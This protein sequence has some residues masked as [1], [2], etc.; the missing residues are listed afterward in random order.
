[1]H[2]VGKRNYN[3]N[4][5]MGWYFSFFMVYQFGDAAWA[6]HQVLLHMMSDAQSVR[7]ATT[8][9]MKKPVK[10]MSVSAVGRSLMSGNRCSQ[11]S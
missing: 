6:G 5:R 2:E 4:D 8:V 9:W 7:P 3:E 11:F 1:M 10:P